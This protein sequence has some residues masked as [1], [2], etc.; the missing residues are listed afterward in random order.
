MLES[1][2]N[3]VQIH[4]FPDEVVQGMLEFLYTGQTKTL[5]ENAVDLLRIGDKYQLLDLKE[6]CEKI[7]ASNLSVENAAEI[8]I[9]A[10]LHSPI[11]LKPKV[12]SFINR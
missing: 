7:I 12:I 1:N 11:T 5:K 3:S 9:V 10:H 4:D 8:L 2:Q 6:I